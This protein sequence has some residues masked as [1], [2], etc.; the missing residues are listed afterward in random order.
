MSSSVAALGIVS[1]SGLIAVIQQ[2]LA[3]ASII[4]ASWGT[5]SDR[6]PFAHAIQVALYLQVIG[7]GLSGL[8]CGVILSVGVD[9][10]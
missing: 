9:L 5:V 1:T 4:S 10:L 8:F 7:L 3:M 2:V 6:L